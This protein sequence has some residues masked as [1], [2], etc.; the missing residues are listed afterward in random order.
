MLH[1]PSCRPAFLSSSDVRFRYRATPASGDANDRRT[2]IQSLHRFPFA[3]RRLC[4]AYSPRIS[5]NADAV[6]LDFEGAGDAPVEAADARH[7][8][9]AEFA[10]V[11]AQG[12]HVRD[13]MRFAEAERFD[14][15]ELNRRAN[16]S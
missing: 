5:L 15:G 8:G 10:V 1:L 12:S 14:P 13:G 3:A 4:S 6:M 11:S 2:A 7:L 9:L 16:C